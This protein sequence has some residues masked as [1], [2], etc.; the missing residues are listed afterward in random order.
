MAFDGYRH[1]E[2]GFRR[3]SLALFAGSL[4]SFG[5]LYCLQPLLPEFT[6][7]FDITP[8]QS[9]LSIS[10][11]TAGLGVG[12]V[13]LG[14]LSDSI[15]RTRVIRWALIGSS[16]LTA[17]C[18]VAPNWT[19]VL[20]MRALTGVALAGF[21]AVAM[22]YLR[23][24]VHAGSH[25]RATG[26]Y[27]GGNALGGLSGRLITGGLAQLGDWHLALIGTAVFT[28]ACAVLVVVVLPASRNF[29]STSRGLTESARA[30]KI[31]LRDP[32]LLG[33]NAISFTVMGAFVAMFNIT[34]F[35]LES[36]PYLL[37]VGLAGLIYLTYPIG[38][39]ASAL[40]GRWSDRIGAHS[41]IPIG[42]IIAIIG[43]TL[44]FAAPLWIFV[45]A[46]TV[47]V[48][49]FFVVH[50]AA[51]GAVAKRAH[52]N[53]MPVGSASAAYLF[54]YYLGSSVFGT[55]AGT[56]WHAGGWSA[57]G[58]MNLALLVVCLSIAILIRLRAREPAQL[59]S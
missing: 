37:P 21:P 13:F 27:V 58:W 39:V 17:L 43:T 55:T 36:A 9:T 41:I 56:A 20:I 19:F 10:M 12:L 44:S 15:G 46:V 8:A 33:Y 18:A 59:S 26:L 16:L 1:G 50:A 23:E 38:S 51:S 54:S 3:V 49:G 14:P 35:R 5:L 25:A 24:E 29:H 48:I 28:L 22:A 52:T 40:A 6:R 34:G 4:A 32:V 53:A 30:Y 45:I 7:A 57:V 11:C 31:V 47:V 42:A 2:A